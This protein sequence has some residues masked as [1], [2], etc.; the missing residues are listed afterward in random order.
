MSLIPP[1]V[2]TWVLRKKS[3]LAT[4]LTVTPAVWFL[5][6]SLNIIDWSGPSPVALMAGT[7]A[8]GLKTQLN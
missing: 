5:D 8:L 1:E 6:G 3:D 4:F 7:G 2:I